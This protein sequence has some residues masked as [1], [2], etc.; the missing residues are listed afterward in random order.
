MISRTILRSQSGCFTRGQGF[1]TCRPSKSAG[2]TSRAKKCHGGTQTTKREGGKEP[3]GSLCPKVCG[4]PETA[5]SR[6][7]PNQA[8]VLPSMETHEQ[9]ACCLG[10]PQDYDVPSPREKKYGGHQEVSTYTNLAEEVV[11]VFYWLFFQWIN[12]YE[13]RDRL[14]LP[15]RLPTTHKIL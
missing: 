12:P 8:S 9:T 13:S 5:S 2:Q 3:L 7:S 1:A 10:T 14:D 11:Y 15:P 4:M 6:S